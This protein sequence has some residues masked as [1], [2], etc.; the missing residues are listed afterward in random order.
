MKTKLTILLTTA[1]AVTVCFVAPST[2]Q[3]LIYQEGFNTDGEAANP[4]RYTTIGR[5]IYTVDRIKAEVDPATQQLGPVYWAHNVDV[6]NS[7]VG[8]PGPTPNLKLTVAFAAT[9]LDFEARDYL[10][11]WI[12][13]DGSGPLDFTRLIHFTAPSDSDKFFDDRSTKPGSPTRLGLN[14]R[15]V[16]YDI[17]AG[18]TQL[19]I[20]FRALTTWWNE[21]AAFDNVRVTEGVAVQ[22]GLTAISSTGNTVTVGW[23]AGAAG[24]VVESTPTL[25][26]TANWTV[27]AGSPNPITGA[28]SINASAAGGGSQFYRLR[29]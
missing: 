16:T 7:F 29:K 23:P 21:I 6:P 1:V 27:V 14:F 20:Q 22:P 4:K 10:A 11:V 28:G 2:A 25:G 8:V 19:V 13:P 5:D 3:Q 24:F 26:P 17:P 12:D 15:D 18:A 9:F